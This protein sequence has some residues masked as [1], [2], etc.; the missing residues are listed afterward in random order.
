MA[1]V[2][3]E[4]YRFVP[5][6]NSLAA[7]NTGKGS[8]TIPGHRE[9]RNVVMIVNASRGVIIASQFDPAKGWTR[10]HGHVY[11]GD[12]DYPDPFFPNALDGTSTI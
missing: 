10:E 8:I 6:D 11:P 7:P 1:Q 4:L 2:K 3:E 5:V 9:T 12:P